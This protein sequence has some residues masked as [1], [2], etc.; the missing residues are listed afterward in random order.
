MILVMILIM[1]IYLYSG[2][3]VPEELQKLFEE[4]KKEQELLGKKVKS[5]SGFTGKGFK[6]DEAEA[7]QAAQVKKR[8]RAIAGMEDSDDEVDDEADDEKEKALLDSLTI[9]S[10]KVTMAG[11]PVG[12]AGKGQVSAADNMAGKTVNEKLEIARQRALNLSMAKGAAGASTPAA[13][14]AAGHSQLVSTTAQ[15]EAIMKGDGF[16]YSMGSIAS[17]VN[18]KSLAEQRAE[19]LHA[20]LNYV[21]KDYEYNEQGE[22]IKR[23]DE[24]ASMAAPAASA[25]VA[26]NA[27]APGAGL[28]TRYEEELEINDAPQQARWRVTSKEAIATISE[29]SEAGITVRGTYFP[30]GK[31]PGPG[32]RKL[33]LAI[34]G[35]TEMAVAKAK[36]EIYRLIK[37]EMAKVKLVS[38]VDDVFVVM[39][40]ICCFRLCAEQQL[41]A[42]HHQGKVQSTLDDALGHRTSPIIVQS[43]KCYCVHS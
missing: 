9:V 33:Y 12:V 10:K 22:I 18:A 20:K 7:M 11:V 34:E 21:P 30:A 14:G 29:F 3:S 15:A 17:A 26:A 39:F 36:A 40:L 2:N 31:E 42:G 6:F 4:F 41:P 27:G 5:S 19:A 32:E 35:M 1:F 25:S 16:S 8:Q 13:F 37:D 43:T 38:C 28:N 23:E 24:L